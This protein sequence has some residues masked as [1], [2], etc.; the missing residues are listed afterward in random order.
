MKAKQL[1]SKA[2]YYDLD[3]M[4]ESLASDDLSVCHWR[5][6]VSTKVA[7]RASTSRLSLKSICSRSRPSAGSLHC[8]SLHWL[9]GFWN[10]S[11]SYVE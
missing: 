2:D 5:V 4:S 1:E 7:K 8:A 3:G 6:V 10:A 11:V 9:L